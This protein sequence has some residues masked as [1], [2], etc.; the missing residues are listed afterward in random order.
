MKTFKVPMRFF[1]GLCLL[2]CGI[3]LSSAC[4]HRPAPV[5]NP[6][7]NSQDDIPIDRWLHVEAPE[8]ADGYLRVYARDP[9]TRIRDFRGK[10]LLLWSVDVGDWRKGNQDF[11]ALKELFES[12]NEALDELAREGKELSVVIFADTLSFQFG[13]EGTENWRVERLAKSRRLRA[14]S[15]TQRGRDQEPYAFL[16]WGYGGIVIDRNGKIIKFYRG[17]IG[18]QEIREAATMPD[19]EK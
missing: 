8:F 1:C 3:L 4:Q 6:N 14:M 15:M 9:K 10:R 2:A 11:H 13:M 16:V 18:P 7:I 17:H 12:V 5:I 19:S